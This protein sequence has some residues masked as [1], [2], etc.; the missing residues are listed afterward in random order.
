MKAIYQKWIV[1]SLKLWP[2]CVISIWNYFHWR[3]WEQI[4]AIFLNIFYFIGAS[5]LYCI[6]KGDV[7]SSWCLFQKNAISVLVYI[8]KGFSQQRNPR[9]EVEGGLEKIPFNIKWLSRKCCWFSTNNV[10][11]NLTEPEVFTCDKHN[12]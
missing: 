6:S 4:Q 12:A 10:K 9:K 2:D 5:L 3:W 1:T 7:T 11:G 8:H